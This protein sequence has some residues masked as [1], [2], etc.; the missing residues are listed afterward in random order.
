M[1]RPFNRS[2]RWVTRVLGAALCLL[3]VGIGLGAPSAAAGTMPTYTVLLDDAHS[4]LFASS[5][6]DRTSVRVLSLNGGSTQVID[7]LWGASGMALS[8]DGALLY[9]AL[10]TGDAIAVIDTVSLSE[11]RRIDTGVASCPIELTATASR[12]WFLDDCVDGDVSALEVRSVD[13]TVDPPLPAASGLSMPYGTRIS[14]DGPFTLLVSGGSSA[15]LRVY[16]G[17]PSTPVLSQT[18]LPD[19]GVGDVVLSHNQG[20]LFV[21]GSVAGVRVLSAAD[22]TLLRTLGTRVGG[23]ISVNP[24][25]T[26]LSL[27]YV[28]GAD[29]LSTSGALIRSVEIPIYWNVAGSVLRETALV[30]VDYQDHVSVVPRAT[31]HVSAL[32]VAIASQP[33]VDQAFSVSGVLSSDKPIAPGAVIHVNRR[34]GTTATALPDAVTDANGH[35]SLGVSVDHS[36][37]ATYEVSYDGDV[38]HDSTTIQKQIQVMG[39]VPAVKLSY[40]PA[41]VDYSKTTTISVRLPSDLTNR[42][43][44]VFVNGNLLK[45]GDADGA[46]LFTAVTHSLISLSQARVRTYADARHVATESPMTLYVHHQILEDLVDAYKKSGTTGYFHAGAGARLRVNENDSQRC[47]DLETQV[48]S[49]GVWKP[50]SMRLN[51]CLPYRAY[52]YFSYSGPKSNGTNARMRWIGHATTLHART[53]GEWRLLRY[54]S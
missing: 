9:V 10:R 2:E 18:V 37:L 13:L 7:G 31:S 20:E 29:V 32:T 15:G 16:D 25:D 21:T 52:G 28:T 47:G 6:P 22:F 26:Y 11:V 12:L 39:L 3:G 40:N 34:M 1:T 23:R 33:K 43:V 5:G 45:V 36:G 17:T 53:T 49:G 38:D 27:Y 14:H 44:A 24:S 50:S 42:R 35:Y 30:T 46:G 48:L 54:T 41:P 51:L 8:P 4:Q 19:E